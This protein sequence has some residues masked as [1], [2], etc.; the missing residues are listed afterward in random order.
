MVILNVQLWE[1]GTQKLHQGLSETILVNTLSDVSEFKKKF[2]YLFYMSS[3]YEFSG[4][5]LPH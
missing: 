4:S 3:Q 2:Q 1:L 5:F